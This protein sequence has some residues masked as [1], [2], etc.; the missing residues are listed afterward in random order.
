VFQRFS[1]RARARAL[2]RVAARDRNNVSSRSIIVLPRE[3]SQQLPLL[4]LLLAAAENLSRTDMFIDTR[5]P[6]T[7]LV[8]QSGR[9]SL[10]RAHLSSHLR[11][12]QQREEKDARGCAY[13]RV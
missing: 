2:F 11:P 3:I 8:T 4:L 13:K 1:A 6:L 10:K 7:S 5:V 12:I 9:G